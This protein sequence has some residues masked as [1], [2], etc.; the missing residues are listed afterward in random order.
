MVAPFG[1]LPG[2]QLIADGARAGQIRYRSGGHLKDLYAA[3]QFFHAN[4][5][6]PGNRIIQLLD[7]EWPRRDL[8]FIQ[9]PALLADRHF[10]ARARDTRHFR[11]IAAQT[12][13][14]HA[15]IG[16]Q[17]YAAETERVKDIGI[18]IILA[19]GQL[20]FQR[21]DCAVQVVAA[22]GK[23]FIGVSAAFVPVCLPVGARA[24]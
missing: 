22:K 13:R 12:W 15:E 19:D 8:S 5:K 7:A 17:A 9:Y 16:I 18:Q 4:I 1:G 20:R 3:V 23:I 21:G 14:Q 11:R 6:S 2:G 10:T 24:P